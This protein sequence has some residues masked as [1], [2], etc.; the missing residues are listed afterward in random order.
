MLQHELSLEEPSYAN[1]LT[2]ATAEDPWVRRNIIR[3]VE[4]LTGRPKIE[5]LYKELRM[6]DLVPNEVWDAALDKLNVVGVYDSQQLAKIP[7]QGP[8]VFVSNHPFGVIDGLLLGQLVSCVRDTFSV[9]VHD[10]LTKQD[11][12]L[13]K[14]LLPVDFKETKDALRTNIETRKRALKT[15]S[16]GDALA[17]FPAGG[18][19]TSPKGFGKAEDHE[20][21]RFT[22]KL[23]QKSR[24]TVVPIYFHG[25]NSRLFQL[26]SQVSQLLRYGLLLHEVRNKMGNHIHIT[27][28]DPIPFE[29]LSELK[30]RQALLDHLREVTYSL[31][32]K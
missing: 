13:D 29:D 7:K 11:A 3:F 27:V 15:L 18:V 17:I 30:D 19:S 1:K 14:F 12:R 32:V 21:K 25:Q 22:A 31:S 23:I 24:A 4:F 26:V 16:E 9:L 10:A 28:G 20:W 8:L 2:Y 5:R 6:M